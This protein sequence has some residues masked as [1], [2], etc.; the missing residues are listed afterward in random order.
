MKDDLL[1]KDKKLIE[2]LTVI[3][4]QEDTIYTAIQTLGGD[5]H[6]DIGKSI[7]EKIFFDFI[8]LPENDRSHD[9]WIGRLMDLSLDSDLNHEYMMVLKESLITGIEPKHQLISSQG[10]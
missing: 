9:Y 3:L 2:A 6:G 4:K 8:C 5:D 10:W 7:K 1:S